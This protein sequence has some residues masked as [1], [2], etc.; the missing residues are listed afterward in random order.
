MAGV[1]GLGSPWVPP[2]HCPYA[3]RRRGA[4]CPWKSGRRPLCTHQKLGALGKPWLTGNG[5]HTEGLTSPVLANGVFLLLTRTVQV[6]VSLEVLVYGRSR[7]PRRAHAELKSGVTGYPEGWSPH[8]APG[9]LIPRREDV[10]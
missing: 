4:N 9:D 8:N 6:L 1:H 3:H 7:G 5:L 10:V 2:H